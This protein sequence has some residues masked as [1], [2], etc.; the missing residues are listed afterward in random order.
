ME[1][2]FLREAVTVLAAAVAVVL[3]CARLRVP[4]VV[5][6][7]LTGLLI[8]PGGLR[9]VAETETV[10]ILAELGVAFLLFAIG[11]ELRL[12]EI[13]ELGRP[14]LLGGSGQCVLTGLLAMAVALA[15]GQPLPTA[16]FLGLALCLS[17]TAVVLKL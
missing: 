8:G 16:V 10:A 12:S 4:S 11:A 5:G 15:L 3:V 7:L 9:W 1:V 13:K 6:L 14:F 17:S 2:A